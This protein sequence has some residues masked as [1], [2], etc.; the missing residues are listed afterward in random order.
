MKLSHRLACIDQLITHSYQDIWDC[1]C[2]HGM[3][4]A[5][6]VQRKA[7]ERVHFVDCV[8]KITQQLEIKLAKHLPYSANSNTSSWRVYCMDSAEISL[9]DTAKQL[10]II[11][12]VGGEL[13]ISILKKFFAQ[14]V[15]KRFELILCPVHHQYELREFL[16]QQ[17][18]GLISEHLV[19]ENKRY[20]EVV[21]LSTDVPQAIS[22]TGSQMWQANNPEHQQY[23]EKTIAHYQR[24]SVS[25][26][27][28]AL[29][30]Y[31]TLLNEWQ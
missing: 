3:L 12:G 15:G 4:G 10:V 2:D 1:C 25:H 18:L 5:H 29:L 26:A 20:Y 13:C 28:P 7:A 22:L 9:E 11:A 16:S 17:K 27:H 19:L 21:H 6:L 24:I 23:L 8:P 31:Q 14:N 30:A